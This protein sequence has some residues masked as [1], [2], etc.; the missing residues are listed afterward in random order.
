M[1]LLGGS[2]SRIPLCRTLGVRAGRG[3]GCIGRQEQS[4]MGTK[5]CPNLP[6]PSA[7]LGRR[8][9]GKA[10]VMVQIGGICGGVV[11]RLLVHCA[12]A[13]AAR[14]GAIGGWLHAL[15][16]HASLAR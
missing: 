15:Y 13:L 8:S 9:S 16:V 14:V 3:S 10:S 5:T 12:C 11:A 7:D 4:V 6:S 1:L 2:K